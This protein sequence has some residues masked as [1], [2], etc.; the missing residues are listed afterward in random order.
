MEEN[1]RKAH[2]ERVWSTRDDTATSW[3]QATPAV[4]L[5]LIERAGA[6]PADPLID[7]GGGASR[8]VDGLLDRGFSDLTVLDLSAAA[9][10]RAR[11]R[12][13]ARAA[14][15][16]W[17]EADVTAFRPA[18]RYRLWHDR[19]VFHFLREAEDRARYVANLDRALAPDG[20][21][22]IATF[23]PD[24]PTRCSGLDI[25]R[26]DAAQLAAQLGPGWV[27]CEE[28]AERHRTPAGGEQ[29]FGFYR[30]ARAGV[31]RSESVKLRE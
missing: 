27:L 4:S 6:A 22:V 20:Q 13:G 31:P 29:R 28:R 21:A 2:W 8:L 18:R 26:Y 16:T 24:G 12:L 1:G 11:Q 5:A 19:A 15:V 14:R 23:A 3:Y 10:D 7:V 17:I 9:L 30:F 25:V